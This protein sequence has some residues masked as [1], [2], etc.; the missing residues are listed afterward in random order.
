MWSACFRAIDF[1][2]LKEGLHVADI[3]NVICSYA[4]INYVDPNDLGN[5]ST[6]RD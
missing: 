3:T 6:D 4:G 5:V 2:L 1:L